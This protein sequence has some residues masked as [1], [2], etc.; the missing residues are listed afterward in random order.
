VRI[1]S[2]GKAIGRRRCFGGRIL[3]FPKQRPIPL[4]RPAVQEANTAVIGLEGA[5]RTAMLAQADQ[6]GAHFRLA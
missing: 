6:P 5:E 2:S 1:W 4:E 3:F